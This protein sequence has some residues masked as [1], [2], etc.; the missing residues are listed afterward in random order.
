[1][2]SGRKSEEEEEEEEEECLIHERGRPDGERGG[3]SGRE[4]PEDNEK[5]ERETDREREL[6]VG[7][8]PQSSCSVQPDHQSHL[9]EVNEL[10]VNVA[11]APL[12]E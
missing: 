9:M 4:R 1:M 12:G 3:K 8:S 11:A 5:K 7:F 6:V 10:I 2:K